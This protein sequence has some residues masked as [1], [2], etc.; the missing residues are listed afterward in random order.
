MA[1]VEYYNIACRNNLFEDVLIRLLKKDGDPDRIVVNYKP[2]EIKIRCNTEGGEGIFAPIVTRELEISF[3]LEEGLEDYWDEFINAQHGIWKAIVTYT[4][5]NATD[6][7][8]QFHGFV[9]PDEGPVPFQDKPYPATIKAT[10]GLSF[11]KQTELTDLNGDRFEGS[12]TWIEYIAA[13]LSK[14]ELELPIRIYDDIYHPFMLTRDNDFKWDCF[15]QAKLEAR[16]FLKDAVDFVDCYE[17]IKIILKRG[18]R[19]FYWN[20][21][22]VIFRLALHQYVPFVLYYTLYDT[23]GQNAV[24]YQEIESYAV[25]GPQREA[26]MYPINK[27]QILS[28][29]FAMKSVKTSFDYDPWPEI[30]KNNKFE[31]GGEIAYGD[32]FDETDIDG[33]DDFSEQIGTYKTFVVEDWE[34]GIPDINDDPAF[35]L[36]HADAPAPNIRRIYNF[37]GI[38]IS[39]EIIMHSPVNPASNKMLWLRSEA[40]PVVEGS[41]INFG[42]DKRWTST[43]SDGDFDKAAIIYLV[44]PTGKWYY[45]HGNPAFTDKYNHW[46]DTGIALS[47]SFLD[48]GF[49]EIHFTEFQDKRKWA[50]VSIE[51]PP[52]PA[53]GNLYIALVNDTYPEPQTQFF[54]NL[55]FEYIPFIAGGFI[56]TEGDY[57]IRTQIKNFTDKTEEKVNLSDTPHKILKG[58]IL[59]TDEN[60]TN[61]QWFRFGLTESRHYKELINI[62][63]Y[64]LLYRRFLT[65]DG[66]FR[67][68]TYVPDNIPIN[69]APIGF[70]KN[71]RFSNFPGENRQFVLLCP[72]EMDLK[73]G[74]TRS[75]YQE[76]LSASTTYTEIPEPFTVF[77][78][79]IVNTLNDVTAA[80]WDS[81]GNAPTEQT[82]FPPIAYVYP[83]DS[84][85]TGQPRAIGIIIN[86]DDNMT[87]TGPGISELYNEVVPDG[88]RL[89]IFQFASEDLTV[90]DEYV[91]TAYGHSESI[92]VGTLQQVEHDDGKLLGDSAAYKY[93]F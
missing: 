58:C 49:I 70:H 66:T 31:H 8:F 19:I 59:D 26:I 79:R 35:P 23:N 12:H 21:Q 6:S 32:A 14:T 88:Y 91:F 29:R 80:Q 61:P 57:W 65:I 74:Q 77:R 75:L 44:T 33:D 82:G 76:V 78:G 64:N 55:T 83:D 73:T 45:L 50:S 69:H 48:E 62:G 36:S 63:E 42:V 17:A 54:R 87:V 60:P 18:Y 81:E 40:I 27:D 47:A 22:F 51:S 1:Y 90:G 9:V 7:F 10:D 4:G 85:I 84:W 92:T 25:V 71:Y 16:T 52:I 2:E 46:L 3:F 43:F 37:F 86:P 15:G 89:I 11:L 68:L 30:P 34:Y 56:K 53:T 20:G 38:E 93:I 72:F 28:A 41:R 39:R 13:A 67:G 5:M 24:G